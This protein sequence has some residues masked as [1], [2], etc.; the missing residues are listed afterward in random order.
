MTTVGRACRVE[1]RFP[2]TS[3]VLLRGCVWTLIT[4]SLASQNNPTSGLILF[5]RDYGPSQPAVTH[6]V[7]SDRLANVDTRPALRSGMETIRHH[8]RE[9]T[10]RISDHGASNPSMVCIHGSGGDHRIWAAQTRLADTVPVVTMNLSG[11][12]DSSELE[13]QPGPETLDAYAADVAAVAHETDARVLLGNSL[14]GAVAMQ[15]ILDQRVSV[16]GLVLAGTGAK[17]GVSDRLLSWL[18]SDS[19]L[20][21][22][23][24][25]LHESDRL[26]HDVTPEKR[27]QSWTTMAEVG[28]KVLRR[29]F[30]TCDRFDIRDRLQELGVPAIAVVGECDS[31]T[32]PSFHRYL[33]SSL[34][35]CDLHTIAAAAH[36]SMLERPIVFNRIVRQFVQNLD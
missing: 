2:P 28:R 14:G 1:L 32:P 34:P 10:Y 27:D 6:A 33:A 24:E 36:L 29:D 20:E 3:A 23:L 17:L 18:D 9:T 13:T 12:G 19:A 31:L 25:Y 5:Q 16:D 11:H 8:G 7:G 21:Q 30:R 4:L 35:A 22:A 26:F 15:A